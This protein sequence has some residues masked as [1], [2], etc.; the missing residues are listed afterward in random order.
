MEEIKGRI[1]KT[2]FKN[3]TNYYSV[4]SF[5]CEDGRIITVTGILPNLD[6]DAMYILVGEYKEHYKYGLQFLV[7]SFKKVLPT[8]YDGLVNYLSG[9]LFLGIGKKMAQNIVDELGENA[10]ELINENPDVLN[11]VAKLT[12]KKR[13]VIIDVLKNTDSDS[14]KIM[15]FF[16]QYGIG[17]KNCLKIEKKYGT[18]TIEI[19][20][21]NP[22]RLVY[23]IDGIGF[24][25]A[26]KIAYNLEIQK[27]DVRRIEAYLLN[28]V[29][30]YTMKSGDS[31]INE[32]DLKKLFY[33]ELSKQGISFEFSVAL[34][35]CINNKVLINFENCIYPKPQYDAETYISSFLTQFPFEGLYDYDREKMDLYLSEIE[36]ILNIKYDDIQLQAIKTFFDNDLMIL[37]GG[38]GTGKTTVV[39]GI[40][41]IFKK[42]FPYSQ[43]CCCAPTGRAAKRLSE[44][45]EINSTTIH[46]LLLWNLETNTFG[47]NDNEPLAID[48]LIIDEFS[49]VDNWLFYNLL[50]ASINVKKICII[51]DENQ[52]PSVGPGSLLKYLIE[53]NLWPT[54]KLKKIFRQQEGSGVIKLANDINN[55]VVDFSTIENDVAFYSLNSPSIGANI[56]KI[57]YNALDKGYSLSDIQVL[58][59]MYRG[60]CGINNLNNILQKVFNPPSDDLR[61]IKLHEKVFRV[62][63]KILQLKNQPDDDVY[64][65]DIGI[66]VDIEYAYEND[67]KQNRIFVDFDGIL[68]EYHQDDFINI[69]HAYCIS[70]HKS[71]GSEYPIVIIPIVSEQR[72]ML[73]KKL[74]YT[75]V[76]RAKKSVIILGDLNVFNM[77]I[78]IGEKHIRKTNLVEFINKK[79][80][81]LD[82]F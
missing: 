78:N 9:P 16:M 72:I 3:Q 44:L 22:Y 43:I 5:E 17:V 60:V 50:K 2:I 39:R 74:I 40:V 29:N 61:E 82:D 36:S 76:T 34:N 67:E 7:E 79:E 32:T 70:I 58:S 33:E 15:Q 30:E 69:T 6:E 12:P 77:G 23:D 18:K 35:G 56:V 20:K 19:I 13:E 1:I 28:L 65:G 49:M 63:D 4:V 10:I 51:G 14:E 66:L 52:L 48:L 62:N 26:D 45:T 38:P 80:M 81:L 21:D 55:N 25:T 47:K 8:S 75:A 54:V 71:Q 37:N 11:R 46:S 57:I 41:H 68:V 73:E 64:N 59:S 31:Y 27:D 24:K 42:L 53:T